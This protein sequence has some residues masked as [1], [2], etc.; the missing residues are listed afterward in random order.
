MFATDLEDTTSA[1]DLRVTAL[2]ENT[3]DD[4]NSSIAE[5][6]E[7]VETLEVT[8]ADHDAEI[9]GETSNIFLRNFYLSKH[10]LNSHEY[11]LINYSNFS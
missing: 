11:C 10:E 9:A 2:E 3:G 6:E 5:L 1:L 4:G 7:R 8:V